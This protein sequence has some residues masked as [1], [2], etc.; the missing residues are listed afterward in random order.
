MTPLPTPE[1]ALT[2]TR[3][4]LAAALENAARLWLD[5]AP[6]SDARALQ[7]VTDALAQMAITDGDD[8]GND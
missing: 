6:G 4:R 3:Q 7:L 2:V 1:R 8:D 5:D